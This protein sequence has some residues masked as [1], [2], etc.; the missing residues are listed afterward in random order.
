MRFESSKSPDRK[1]AEDL[2]VD[3]RKA[4]KDGQD[5]EQAKKIKNYTFKELATEYLGK[6]QHQ[7]AISSKEGFVKAL[8]DRFGNLPLRHIS[9]RLIED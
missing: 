6:M 4:V 3:K 9:N 8:V 1:A 7:K 5:T 2:L